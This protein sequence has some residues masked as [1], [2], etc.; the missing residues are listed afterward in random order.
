MQ[1]RNKKNNLKY[2]LIG[3]TGILPLVAVPFLGFLPH[4]NDIAT[5]TINTEK[6]N[7][8]RDVSPNVGNG[9]AK[10]EFQNAIYQDAYE[11]A[12]YD[13]DSIL[14]YSIYW[15][16]V[17]HRFGLISH[18]L[19]VLEINPNQKIYVMETSGKNDYSPLLAEDA[20]GNR[21]YPNVEIVE[22]A[23]GF[24]STDGVWLLTN[25]FITP[26]DFFNK[27]ISDNTNDET[28]EEPRIH[29]YFADW[30]V[31][32]VIKNFFSGS[33]LPLLRKNI[34]D[35]W[36]LFNKFESFSIFADGTASIDFFNTEF[37]NYLIKA[38]IGEYA[39]YS[40]DGSDNKWFEYE[41]AANFRKEFLESQKKGEDFS[42]RFLEKNN[43]IMYIASLIIT[44]D[45]NGDNIYPKKN[46]EGNY[47]KYTDS[48]FFL[49]TTE[50]IDDVNRKDSTFLQSNGDFLNP[51][52][53]YEADLLQSFKTLPKDK[54]DELT[55]I[56]KA[57]DVFDDPNLSK[58]ME[59]KV[60]VVYSGTLL[61][62][63]DISTEEQ[64]NVRKAEL[65]NLRAINIITKKANPGKDVQIIYK[66][67]PRDGSDANIISAFNETIRDFYENDKDKYNIPEI[68][69]VEP[70]I[71]YELYLFSGIFDSDPLVNKEVKLY[72]SF[73]TIIWF[74][75]ADERIDDIINIAVTDDGVFGRDYIENT[76]GLESK[77]FNT[78]GIP[79]PN[80]KIITTNELLEKA[81]ISKPGIK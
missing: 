57:K 20:D 50:F 52:N 40:V 72:S 22:P 31:Y 38:G 77:I 62:N 14:V 33:S 19:S 30:T 27:I 53:S 67:H 70:T 75:Y 73:S 9:T 43:A 34:Y 23:P 18:I 42:H 11:K 4:Q 81:G 41:E 3:L 56:L 37:Y 44:K 8:T 21:K 24:D 5:N 10:A 15:F 1:K 13:P 2:I 79:E 28:N 46:S 54:F 7:T 29:A 78:E 60:N 66:G 47:V 65:D 12:T 36:G 45:F 76:Y 16:S 74:L 64:Q 61:N 71:P 68:Y 63:P 58:D 55:K 32:N 26:I 48:K 59:N 69:V 49:P 17:F 51:Y 25:R 39:E 6:F 35:F 80:D